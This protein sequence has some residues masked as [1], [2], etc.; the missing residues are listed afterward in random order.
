MHGQQRT[1][2]E[3]QC[4]VCNVINKATSKQNERA[5]RKIFLPKVA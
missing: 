1:K 4:V 3:E 5:E 2:L